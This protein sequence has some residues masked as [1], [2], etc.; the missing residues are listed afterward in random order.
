MASMSKLTF[1][2]RTLDS[3]KPMAIYHAEQLPELAETTNI[4][5]AVT[6]LPTHTS[7]PTGNVLLQMIKIAMD[8]FN[9]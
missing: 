8:L 4:N 5:R 1:R 9:G 2:S 6:S 7:L 3:S